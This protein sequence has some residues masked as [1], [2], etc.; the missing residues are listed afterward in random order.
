MG[1]H[2]GG[3]AAEGGRQRLF[4]GVPLPED[5][6]DLVRRAQHSL[7]PSTGLRLVRPDHLHVTLAFIGEVDG[8]KAEA[9][10]AVVETLPA[11]LGGT[12]DVTG[13]LMLPSARRARVVALELTDR[14]RVFAGLFER[15]MGGLE[16]AAVM[17]REGRPFRPHLT[18]A[19]LKVPGPV[20]P[21]AESGRAPYAVESVCLYKS[22]LKREGA[23]YIVLARA[24]FDRKSGTTV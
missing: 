6:L 23:R 13:F 21:R 22:E 8:A 4:I 5:L 24:T 19:R 14:E 11:G 7:P 2:P 18:I 20:Q 3:D 9:A 15:A 1:E 12:A 16:A 10:R 17:V